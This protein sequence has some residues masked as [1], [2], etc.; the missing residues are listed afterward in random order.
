M[1]KNKIAVAITLLIVALFFIGTPSNAKRNIFK[2]YQRPVR[3]KGVSSNKH[4]PQAKQAGS[5]S[6]L[7]FLS[8]KGNK[9]VDETGAIVYLRG[10]HYD[11]FSS[12][13]KKIFDFIKSKGM[14]PYKAN[15]ELSRFWFTD[16]DISNIKNM[17]ANV[18]RISIKLWQIE[19]KP[20]SY[21]QDSLRHLDNVVQRFGAQGIYVILDLHAAGQNTLTHNR[22]YGNIL[23]QDK[24]M[25]KRVVALWEMLS[26]R[27]KNTPYIAGYDILNEPTAPSKKALHALYQKIIDGI[28]RADKKHILFVETNLFPRKYKNVY[29]G[30]TY[31]DK[32][33][34]LSL[35]FYKPP[36]FTNQGIGS[37]STGQK[38]PGTYRKLYWDKKQIANYMAEFLNM[39]EA[40]GRPFYVGEFSANVWYG[41][42]DALRWT[43]DAISVFKAKG[44]HF[45]YFQYKSGM[46][47]Q[48]GYFSP[49]KTTYHKMIAMRRKV[50]RRKKGGNL[51]STEDMR[52]N[53]T[54]NF[55]TYSKLTTVLQKGFAR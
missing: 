29:F 17:G 19:N 53:L 26:Q 39:P 33:I 7:T 51:L 30:G 6:P 49:R 11:S 22:E 45:T 52:L 21:S 8:V 15:V 40:R 47:N 2:R 46:L 4:G 20:F 42:A 9:V 1:K 3:L 35:H 31:S 10:F 24:K 55:E 5:L 16:K 41:G 48:L 34:V 32:N 38:Y 44:I 37:R 50:K 12:L 18:V 36:S 23:W 28:R 27:Y 43:E 54:Q 25:Q 13:Q 14:N